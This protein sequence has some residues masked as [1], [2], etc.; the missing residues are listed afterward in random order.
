MATTT[1]TELG[2]E[3]GA[4][5]VVF[6]PVGAPAPDETPG[7][8]LRAVCDGSGSVVSA[9][10]D[11]D[12]PDD[13]SD[14]TVDGCNLGVPTAEPLSAGTACMTNGGSVC[15]SEGLCVEPT[16]L[17]G[18][19][20]GQE[21]D[22]DCGGPECGPCANGETCSIDD[23]CTALFCHPTTQTCEQPS[24]SDGF[25]NGDETGVDCGGT[26][27][28]CG[29]GQGC[30]VDLDCTSG[31]CVQGLCGPINGCSIG[32]AFDLTG[33]PDVTVS[34]TNALSYDPK[35]VR[36]SVGAQVTFQGNFSVHPLLGGFV[37]GGVFPAAS[38][39]FV[40]VTNTGMSKSVVM[41]SPGT[42]PYYCTAHALA[43]MTGVVFVVP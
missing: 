8:C 31:A 33:Q 29:D 9:P 20:D 37:S 27:G 17:D 12:L 10:D 5:V 22:I 18:L 2:C 26:C 39:P 15:D 21:T 4:C 35:C 13:G 16:C 7:D 28:A 6:K 1:C 30:L 41:L 38:G 25:S 23:D 3:D 40:P 32:S 11:S 19:L 43:G 42:F 36:V 24:C 34:F 14:C